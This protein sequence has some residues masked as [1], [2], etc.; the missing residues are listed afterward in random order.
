MRHDLRELLAVTARYLWDTLRTEWALAV[1]WTCAAAY[2][3]ANTFDADTPAGV[4]LHGLL[5]ALAL[6][7]AAGA[8]R[9]A[10][11]TEITRHR[12]D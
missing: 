5:C 10:V 7:C 8:W 1:L 4:L 2:G 12:E 6:V 11:H 9:S 3:Y